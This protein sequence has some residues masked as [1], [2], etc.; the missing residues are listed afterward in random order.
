MFTY[1]CNHE[2]TTEIADRSNSI[3]SIT[4][5]TTYAYDS[6]VHRDGGTKSLG[7][8][9]LTASQY[10]FFKLSSSALDYATYSSY[11]IIFYARYS[12]DVAIA[13]NKTYDS[14]RMALFTDLSNK[15]STTESSS[16]LDTT[17]VS[18]WCKFDLTISSA[19]PSNNNETSFQYFRL[20]C[21]YAM[22]TGTVYIDDLSLVCGDMRA[23]N[24][25]SNETNDLSNSIAIYSNWT[26]NFTM[27][28]NEDDV[29]DS[30]LSSYSKRIVCDD[31][32]SKYPFFDTVRLG[33][34]D[35]AGKTLTFDIKKVSNWTGKV[36][37][38]FRDG[39]NLY[40]LK[41]ADISTGASGVTGMTYTALSNGWYRVSV[42]FDTAAAALTGTVYKDTAMPWSGFQ[43]VVSSHAQVGILLI[44]NMTLA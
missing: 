43:F 35:N 34:N 21:N 40:M 2:N 36:Q 13:D 15:L 11:H 12:S 17:Y 4:S 22:T 9:T 42:V 37:I 16:H 41:G 1:T 32:A 25:P 28:A 6:T 7:L 30:T 44:D 31:S 19:F 8:T 5:G 33:Q 27:S 3:G 26:T 18:N 39:A 10:V 20:C 29:S 14:L 24:A 23:E 38:E